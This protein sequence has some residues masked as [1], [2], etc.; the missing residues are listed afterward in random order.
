MSF[1]DLSA[2]ETGHRSVFRNG[3][4]TANHHICIQ[5]RIVLIP[6]SDWIWLHLQNEML[7]LL[8]PESKIS[9]MKGHYQLMESLQHWHIGVRDRQDKED[10]D[11]GVIILF[12]ILCV[13]APF[14][15]RPL[16]F[17]HEQ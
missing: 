8:A 1:Y 7:N 16:I 12:D 14:A 11:I 17:T 9:A 6:L 5:H 13:N 3:M 15:T 2:L 10:M 4:T